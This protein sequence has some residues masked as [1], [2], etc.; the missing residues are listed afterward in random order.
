MA[1]DDRL[2]QGY[3]RA[4]FSVAE[5]EGSLEQVEDEL[6]RFAKAAEGQSK[7]RDALTDPRLL[8]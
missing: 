5:A 1:G 7:L 3:A 4:L 6:Y 8:A 2:V